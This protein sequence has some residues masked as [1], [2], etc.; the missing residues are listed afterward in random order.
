MLPAASSKMGA[1][2]ALFS[3][4]SFDLKIDCLVVLLHLL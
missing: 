2:R 3:N 1:N 4:T